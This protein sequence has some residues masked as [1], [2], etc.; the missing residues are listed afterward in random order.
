IQF[1]IYGFTIYRHCE[2]R[3][4]EA[5]YLLLWIASGVA[6]AMTFRYSLITNHYRATHASPLLITIH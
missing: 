5:I 4:G 1:T 6:L 3:S 2:P